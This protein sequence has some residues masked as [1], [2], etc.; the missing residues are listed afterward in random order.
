MASDDSEHPGEPVLEEEE[1]GGAAGGAGDQLDP[2]ER[3]LQGREDHLTLKVDDL[4]KERE[5][6]MKQKKEL[7]LKLKVAQKKK[8]RLKLKTRG[9]QFHQDIV[10][11]IVMR[12]KEKS[13]ADK[14]KKKM[15]AKKSLPRAKIVKVCQ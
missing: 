4:K 9:R 7:T 8:K 6:L 11:V 3:L 1:E 12:A 14:R 10:D 5:A 15:R 13:I 2:L